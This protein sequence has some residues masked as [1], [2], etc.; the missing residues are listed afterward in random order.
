[1]ICILTTNHINRLDKTL[2]EA[3][4]ID[5]LVKLKSINK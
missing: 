3:R 4:R 2:T 5:I 1:M